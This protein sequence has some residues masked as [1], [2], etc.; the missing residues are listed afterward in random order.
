MILFTSTASIQ[1]RSGKSRTGSD[2]FG[3]WTAESVVFV[4]SLSTLFA[5]LLIGVSQAVHYGSFYA[6]FGVTIIVSSISTLGTYQD[7]RIGI[8][9]FI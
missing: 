5:I 8:R 9:S 7:F 6:Y 3:M 1:C 2:L 4:E